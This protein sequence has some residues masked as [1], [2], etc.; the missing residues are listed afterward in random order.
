VRSVQANA[1]GTMLCFSYP[2]GTMSSGKAQF[3]PIR[4][5]HDRGHDIRAKSGRNYYQKV[6][7]ITIYM[8]LIQ[9]VFGPNGTRAAFFFNG[10]KLTDVYCGNVLGDVWLV[11]RVSLK[12]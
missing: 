1:H 12:G 3:V 10:G 9:L 5:F 6:G 4:A 7:I 11:R 8:D 2:S